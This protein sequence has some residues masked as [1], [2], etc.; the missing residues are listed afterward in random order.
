MVE[1]GGKPV[2]EH[3]V[4]YLNSFGITEIIVNLHYLPM[5]IMEY[6]GTRLLY[7]YE[8]TLLGEQGTILALKNWFYKDVL[9][10]MNGDTLTNID[11]KELFNYS[12]GFNCIKSMEDDVYT[13]TSI[14][15][16]SYFW[17]PKIKKVQTNCKWI[18]IGNPKNLQ[19]AKEIYEKTGNLSSLSN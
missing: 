16:T 11:I 10:V 5:K 2:L 4:N 9:V 13:G 6:F 12:Y 14:Y 17:H 8:P 3:L 19:K 18:D 15:R 1:V 7:F